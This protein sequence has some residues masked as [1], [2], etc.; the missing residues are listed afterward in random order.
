[1]KKKIIIV[2]AAVIIV[3]AGGWGAY[4][5]NA[6]QSDPKLSPK[7]IQQIV[8][9]QYPGEIMELDLDKDFSKAVYTV[10]IEGKE[11][12]YELKMDG[13]TGEVLRLKEM[14]QIPETGNAKKD[15]SNESKDG[16]KESEG[17]SKGNKTSE[18]EQVQSS[19][20]Q[21]EEKPSKQNDHSHKNRHKNNQERMV[22]SADEASKIALKQFP[23]TVTELELDEDDGRYIYEIE[24][25][26]GNDKEAE[27][28]IDAMTGETISLEI[29]D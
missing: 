24:I 27:F 15:G 29:D 23:G 6:S 4:H 8:K 19:T 2:V 1:M 28:E 21:T 10:A 17:D 12:I 11:K 22:I 14:L 13:N 25:E 5:S 20:S 16:S 3:A 18:R 26:N 7:D 9:D